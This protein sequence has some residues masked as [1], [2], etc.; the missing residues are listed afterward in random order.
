MF[1]VGTTSVACT[2]VDAAGN[3]ASASFNVVV[4]GSSVGFDV[5][6]LASGMGIG[7]IVG[8]AAML[9]WLRYG[10]K[11]GPKAGTTP[12]AGTPPEEP[13]PIDLPPPRP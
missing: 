13:D 3:Q 8:V 10:R 2:A 12:G 4:R 11:P 5:G 1:P 9:A 6:V 7:A